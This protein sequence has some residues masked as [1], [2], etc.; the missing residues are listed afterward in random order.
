MAKP[1]LSEPNG[2]PAR[3]QNP[4]PLDDAPAPDAMPD[5]PTGA[6]GA[7]QDAAAPQPRR[8]GAMVAALAGG[9]LAGAA[10][11]GAALYLATAYPGVI[12]APAPADLAQ[13]LT[14]IES[15][16]A[17]LAADQS[18]LATGD[19]AALRAQIASVADRPTA[20]AVDPGPALADLDRRM[21]ALQ[22]SLTK[23][24]SA[25]VT[26]DGATAAD[27]AADRQ[28]AQAAAAEAARLM[29][30]A[31]TLARNAE[32]RSTLAE[33]RAAFDSGAPMDGILGRLAGLG[34]PTP[35]A[36]AQKDVPTAAEL[37]GSF[38]DAARGALAVSL[39]ETA[40]ETT[41]GKLTAFLRSQTG[42]RSLTPQPGNDPDAILSRAEAAVA[43][44]DLAAALAE[45]AALPAGG[46][47]EMA[48]WAA[49]AERRLAAAKALARLADGQE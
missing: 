11:F 27:I 34:L 36:L 49:Q 25:A 14:T 20:P 48:S 8:A 19:I 17:D 5:R 9:I 38:P 46:Q 39:G 37:A 13:R 24:T 42:V 33:L 30:E 10:G 12:T 28:A 31:E 6:D 23:L 1:K 35:D 15:R 40:G 18:A 43:T 44:G 3:D 26:A 45:V 7:A 32:I 16:L 41:W 4:V 22:A 29:G 21:T 2:E 47:A